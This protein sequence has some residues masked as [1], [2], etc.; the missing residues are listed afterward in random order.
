MGIVDKLCKISAS[1]FFEMNFYFYNKKFESFDMAN[2]FFRQN[3]FRFF[4]SP[5]E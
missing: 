3:F 2:N 1:N 5:G 4:E